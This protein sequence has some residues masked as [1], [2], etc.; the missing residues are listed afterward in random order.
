MGKA[1]FNL[2][3][4]KK[5]L[6]FKGV[7]F[8]VREISRGLTIQYLDPLKFSHWFSRL[9]LLRLVR[10][11]RM[12]AKSGS[13]DDKMLSL[14]VFEGIKESNYGRYQE[15]LILT[16][17]ETSNDRQVALF[18]KSAP[19]IHFVFTSLLL[20]LRSISEGIISSLNKS[21]IPANL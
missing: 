11:K 3:C 18:K 4:L 2:V 16:L 8:G 5:Q 21:P 17:H 13:H 15:H 10:V 6:P 19:S 9:S 12:E 14:V 7:H 1:D 20:V